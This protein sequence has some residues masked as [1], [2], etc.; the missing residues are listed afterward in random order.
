MVMLGAAMVNWAVA[1][2]ALFQTLLFPNL[3]RHK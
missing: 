3:V 1:L 2:N